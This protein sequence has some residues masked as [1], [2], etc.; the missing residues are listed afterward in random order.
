M[1]IGGFKLATEMI[2][3]ICS[4]FTCSYR[5]IKIVYTVNQ[6]IKI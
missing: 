3:A 2:S 1:N 6:L 5:P 4:I